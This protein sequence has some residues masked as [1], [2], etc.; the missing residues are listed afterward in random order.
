MEFFKDLKV[1]FCKKV[2]IFCK[3]ITKAAGLGIRA[4]YEQNSAHI[5]TRILI[6]L[7]A[8]FNL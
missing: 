8:D 6:R 5:L 4:E 1:F 7:A 2:N 3:Y